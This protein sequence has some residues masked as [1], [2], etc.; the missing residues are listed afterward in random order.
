MIAAGVLPACP[1]AWERGVHALVSAGVWVDIPLAGV[2]PSHVWLAIPAA[3]VTC[4]AGA[5][6]I[7]SGPRAVVMTAALSAFVHP[8]LPL[9]LT[10]LVMAAR[11]WPEWRRWIW[12]LAGAAAAAAVALLAT[13]ECRA[14]EAPVPWRD[15]ALHAAA[16]LG[17]AGIA[18]TFCDLGFAHDARRL[19]AGGLAVAAAAGALAAN[20]L[21]DATAALGAALTVFW[22]RAASGGGRILR[23]QATPGARTSAAVILAAVPI[24]AVEPLIRSAQ[25]DEGPSAETVW[26]ALDGIRPPAAII[27][28]GG[29]ADVAAAVWRAA[30][31]GPARE[32]L[33]V[34]SPA[35]PLALTGRDVYAWPQAAGLLRVRG[36]TLG[37]LGNDAPE[38][39]RVLDEVPC[40]PLTATWTDVRE[41]ATAAQLTGVFPEVAPLRGVLL[42]VAGPNPLTPRPVGWPPDAAGGFEVRAFDRQA[43]EG[44]AALAEAL[45]RDALNAGVFGN[46]RFAVRV[47]FDRRASAPEA[48]RISFGA[49]LDAAWARRYTMDERPE[50]RQPALCRDTSGQ[51]VTAFEGAAPVA[52]LDLSSPQVTG[53][54][55]QRTGAAGRH[56]AGPEADLFYL[57]GQPRPLRL[58]IDAEPEGGDWASI[59]VRVTLNGVASPCLEG[60]S[61]CDWLLPAEG[62]RRGLNVVTLHVSGAGPAAP[63]APPRLLVRGA[64]LMMVRVAR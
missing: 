9:A 20:A 63:V 21:M 14:A 59:A 10:P 36:F 47:R 40:Q 27:S 6:A 8:W 46:A 56:L 58:Q 50:E 7:W 28:T 12:P 43:P 33:L 35:G 15:L 19:Q 48:L 62:M 64:R 29:R 32:L 1:A 4:A 34:P 2:V 13:P 61:P 16:G 42:Y 24:L 22:W 31:P 57:A 5:A 54:G 26:R 38:L 52:V 30:T 45:G 53:R 3:A 25:G 60:V 37:P 39:F 41:Q 44:A 23:W 49:A 11:P 18:L 51:V 55:W 17:A